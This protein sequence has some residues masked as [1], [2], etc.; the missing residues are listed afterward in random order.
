M[1]WLGILQLY[2]KFRFFCERQMSKYIINKRGVVLSAKWNLMLSCFECDLISFGFAG[3][4]SKISTE[5]IG[6]G[7][8]K[9]NKCCVLLYMLEEVC[10]EG[11]A[12]GGR[13]T[14]Q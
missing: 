3:F 10:L 4:V 9:S 11:T 13:V 7:K 12:R 2:S 5:E 1:K 8:D 6:Y 14:I